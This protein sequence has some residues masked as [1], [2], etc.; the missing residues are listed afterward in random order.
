MCF[1][2]FVCRAR[3]DFFMI[4]ISQIAFIFLSIENVNKGKFFAVRDVLL[5]TFIALG[6]ASSG[7]A[8]DSF[9]IKDIIAGFAGVML[10]P[11]PIRLFKRDESKEIESF[12]FKRLSD[13]FHSRNFVWLLIDFGV[14]D[15][16]C[17]C[18]RHR[19]AGGCAPKCAAGLEALTFQICL[20]ANMLWVIIRTVT[21]ARS[22]SRSEYHIRKG[23]KDNAIS[24]NKGDV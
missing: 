7:L 5:C 16:T 3:R 6:L 4:P 10:I 23:G 13:A 24:D 9:S 8:V 20:R 1:E 2:P 17:L 19:V 22:D 18:L 11:L 14:D 12:G 21:Y 15:R